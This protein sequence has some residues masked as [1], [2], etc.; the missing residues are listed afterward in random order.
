MVHERVLIIASH[1]DDIEFRA[2][3]SA[4]V[5]TREGRLV[6]YVL[7]TSGEKG[8]NQNSAPSLSLK[9]RRAIREEEQRAAAQV[10][11]VETVHFLRYPD[12]EMANTAELRRDLVRVIREMKPDTVV[13]GDPSMD[14]YDSFY[15]Y[16]RDHRVISQA[17]FD[18]LYPAAGN[19]NYF[20][21]LIKEGF[22]PHKPA[23]VYFGNI[24]QP[25]IWV[26]ISDT[27]D[28]KIEALAC[29]KSQIDDIEETASLMRDWAKRM[30]KAKGLECAECFRSL[31][32]P[33]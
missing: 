32:I 18:A 7:S 4:A 20:P 11:G 30:G 25:D 14:A 26:D 22:P 1:P 29:H 24:H 3:G 19:E 8:F 2:A 10:V 13:S 15:G 27:F 33:D 6:E 12:G 17:V 28:L 31:S 9:D 16:H 21:E 5:W 23:E